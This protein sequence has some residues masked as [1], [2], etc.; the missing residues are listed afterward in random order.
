M[1]STRAPQ[2]EASLPS[3]AGM[4][5]GGGGGGDEETEVQPKV[6]VQHSAHVMGCMRIIA[7]YYAG[8][9]GYIY[10]RFKSPNF[11]L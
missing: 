9:E 1:S 5:G 8:T 6:N 10:I 3:L 4:G 7:L 2:V 11:S